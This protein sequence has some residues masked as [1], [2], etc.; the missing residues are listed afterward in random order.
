MRRVV[1]VRVSWFPLVALGKSQERSCHILLK[2]G[3]AF[4]F[5]FQ[6]GTP[7]TVGTMPVLVAIAPAHAVLTN[8]FSAPG[9]TVAESANLLLLIRILA[10]NFFELANCLFLGCAKPHLAAYA[11]IGISIVGGPVEVTDG[12]G[13]V[14]VHGFD[15]HNSPSAG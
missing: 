1:R 5:V 7:R 14:D 9:T 3:F 13:R 6:V 4:G 2:V 8:L 12:N 11:V 10:K 15:F